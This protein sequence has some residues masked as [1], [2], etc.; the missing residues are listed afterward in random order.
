MHGSGIAGFLAGMK[1]NEKEPA[2][3]LATPF[4]Y[5]TGTQ[6]C[7]FRVLFL[8]L[9]DGNGLPREALPQSFAVTV[10]HGSDQDKPDGCDNISGVLMR[11]LEYGTPSRSEQFADAEEKDDPE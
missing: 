6:R 9:A 1:R 2:Q 10:K 5:G 7:L 8:S 3:H 4:R 11:Q